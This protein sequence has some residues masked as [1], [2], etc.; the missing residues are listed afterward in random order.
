M[1]RFSPPT[2]S[3]K[4]SCVDAFS[5]TVNLSFTDDRELAY[6]AIQEQGG[7]PP[8]NILIFVEPGLATI[9]YPLTVEPGPGIR[10]LLFLVSNTNGN[11]SK[12]LLE[13]APN[14]CF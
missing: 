9:D 7:N 14:I 10:K 13:I 3:Y 11:V 1:T 2:I 8:K 6:F 4:L 12:S 5:L